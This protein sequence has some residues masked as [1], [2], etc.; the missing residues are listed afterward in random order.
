MERLTNLMKMI[1][2][3]IDQKFTGTITIH[4]HEGNVSRKID[5]KNIELII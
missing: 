1:K 5:K 2:L 4:F 3:L